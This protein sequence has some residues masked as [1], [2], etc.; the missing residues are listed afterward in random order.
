MRVCRQKHERQREW[1]LF[2]L[3]CFPFYFRYFPF[4]VSSVTIWPGRLPAVTRGRYHPR[5]H[6]FC[7]VRLVQYGFK[8]ARR[9]KKNRQK[10]EKE[11]QLRDWLRQVT[12]GDNERSVHSCK[13]F[14]SSS[15]PRE[16]VNCLTGCLPYFAIIYQPCYFQRASS[17]FRL[18]CEFSQKWCSSFFSLFL[19]LVGEGG[20]GKDL[21]G[22]A[23]SLAS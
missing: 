3:F 12:A 20:R 15:M 14:D 11:K 7:P 2:D 8:V 4:L 5:R 21:F 10:W 17:I 23:Y 16:A 18:S 13:V 19:F 22:A 1:C 9:W 6:R